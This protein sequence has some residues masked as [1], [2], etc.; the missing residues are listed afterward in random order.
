MRLSTKY[1]LIVIIAAVITASAM[2]T[3]IYSRVRAVLQE[4]AVQAQL[5]AA[6][7]ILGQID[8]SLSHARRDMRILVADEFLERYV[9]SPAYRS[10][11]NHSMLAQEIRER[12]ETTG[13]WD[14]LMVVDPRGRYLI[15]TKPHDRNDNIDRDPAG[16]AAFQ[17]ALRGE[18]YSSDLI[19]LGHDG[20]PTL[21]FA[22]PIREQPNS[23]DQGAVI[24]V[25][26]AQYQ[27]SMV[28][29]ILKQGFQK[30][31]AIYLFDHNGSVIAQYPPGQHSPSASHL[32]HHAHIQRALIATG[33]HESTHEGE[34]GGN[35][36]LSAHVV[37]PGSKGWG[38]AIDQ[39]ENFFF[40]QA[41]RLAW[42]AALTVVGILAVLAA[43]LTLL[44]SRLMKP[45][46]RLT[47]I[48]EQIGRGN[49]QQHVDY[50][51][52]DE[53]GTLAASFNTMIDQLKIHRSELMSAKNLIQG[54]VDTVPGIL[55]TAMPH[56][57]GI[58]FVSPAVTTLLGFEAEAFLKNPMLRNSLLLEEDRERV[59]TE[60][61][62]AKQ[63]NTDFIVTYRMCHKDGKTI[64]WFEDRGSWER[65]PSGR[66]VALH[67]V[68]MDIT[69]R[70]QREE[71]LARTSRALNI[72]HSQDSLLTHATSETELA[73]GVCAN[74]VDQQV[75]QFAWV[76]LLN[77]EQPPHLH[78]VAH[79][80][81]DAE[82]ATNLY[83]AGIDV[84]DSG[85]LPC[86]A[87]R[88]RRPCILQD[89]LEH[90]SVDGTLQ[91]S[92][93]HYAS[94]ISLPLASEHEILGSLNI[95]SKDTAVFDAPELKL[96]EEIAGN[97]AYGITAL[98]TQALHNQAREQL[99]HQASHDA[100]TGLPN[101]AML[102]NRLQQ[103]I[104]HAE[105]ADE[106]L[107]VL[108]I[109]LDD[110]KLVNDTLGHSCGDELLHQVGE[111]IAANIRGSDVVARQ[112]GDEFIVLMN[113]IGAQYRR[114]APSPDRDSLLLSPEKQ[115]QR[116]INRIKEPFIIE[117]HKTYIGASIGIALYPHDTYNADTLLRYAD[118]AMYHAKELGKNNYAFYS[119]ELTERQQKRM[120]LANLLHQAL[121]REE[122][123][124]LY[125]PII[126]LATGA[127]TGVEALI[128]WQRQDGKIIPPNDFLPVAEDTGLIIPIGDWVLREACRQTKDWLTQG[129]ELVVAVNLSPRQLW[130]DD[131]ADTILQIITQTGLSSEFL[132]LEITE[133]AMA[134]DPHH[135]ETALMHFHQG[136]IKIAL[137]DFGTGYSS[138]S[139]LKHL[140]I[141]TLKIDKSFVDGV[142]DDEDNSA[143]VTA[144]MQLAHSLG[145]KSLAEGIETRTQWEWLR[146]R[147]CQYGQGYYFSRPVPA[148]EITAMLHQGQRWKFG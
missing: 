103:A 88:E 136:G 70:K 133:S 104:V 32:A 112:G 55:Y 123:L 66:I 44:G 89:P 43:V 142:P 6:H 4:R 40:A 85:C 49:F 86:R 87:I 107:A 60:V 145:L 62:A 132:E 72:L 63:Q 9:E 47:R 108:F 128:R 99:A 76:G 127:L 118:S 46:G 35:T 30:G 23:D 114:G 126:E 134:Y 24:G 48:T 141:H 36:V 51:S 64:R 25:M 94:L 129:L 109:D 14:D 122:F 119:V 18:L 111:R 74:I 39:S 31:A 115:A 52:N 56:N 84:T 113:G 73:K 130:H 53:I 17:A 19:S 45:L 68:M 69:K 2:G 97:L 10:D 101:R 131:I 20:R 78:A 5:A 93:H 65:D 90:P 146:K 16:Y 102:M 38:L 26:I 125:Q 33:G 96:L 120:S 41:R 79:A 83:Q 75:Y 67:G 139:R 57:L 77:H 98:R 11:L 7:H 28:T 34:F 121:E 105:R 50:T 82:L 147:G 92:T 106:I 29:G 59:L 80:G 61:E 117:G 42:Q 140:P 21:I 54:I 138:L 144:T 110:F 91:K 37:A 15:T 124:L 12:S 13:P 81:I 1:G 148:M 58:I 143:I 135:L 3:L 116:L 100:L 71:Q 95:Y 27:W 22:A 137:D 8:D